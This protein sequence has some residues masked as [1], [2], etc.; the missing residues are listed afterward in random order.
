MFSFITALYERE[1]PTVIGKL[2]PPAN[3]LKAVTPS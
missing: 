1:A 2:T 3:Y